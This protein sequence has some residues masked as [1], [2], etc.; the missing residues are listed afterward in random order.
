MHMPGRRPNAPH[1]AKLLSFLGWAKALTCPIWARHTRRQRN[2]SKELPPPPAAREDVKSTSHMRWRLVAALAALIVLILAGV[3]A[4]F[5]A[6]AIWRSSVSKSPKEPQTISAVPSP[7]RAPDAQGPSPRKAQ[8]I[9]RNVV[10]VTQASTWRQGKKPF[11]IE[12]EIRQRLASAGVG[13]VPQ[14]SSRADGT[15]RIIYMETEG[16]SYSRGGKG[17]QISCSVELEGSDS[18]TLLAHQ[19]RAAS[20]FL[21]L[22]F[23]DKDD[24]LY[25]NA[26]G[27]LRGNAVYEHLEYLVAGALGVNSALPHVLTEAL[28]EREARSLALHVLG[29]N[30]FQPSSQVEE[31]YLAA[32]RGQFDDCAR[33]GEAAVEPL[34]RMSEFEEVTLLALSEPFQTQLQII[35]A[36]G[37]IG[38]RTATEKLVEVLDRYA[39]AVPPRVEYT[40]SDVAPPI[41]NAVCGALQH[42]DDPAAKS[43]IEE[44]IRRRRESISRGFPQETLN[45]EIEFLEQALDR[46]NST[47]RS[48]TMRTEPETTEPTSP[49]APADSDQGPRRRPTSF[50]VAPTGLPTESPQPESLTA[51]FRQVQSVA[52]SGGP[53]GHLAD[54]QSGGGASKAELSAELH[55]VFE[56]SNDEVRKI[57]QQILKAYNYEP[58]HWGEAQ[59][60]AAVGEAAFVPNEL[61]RIRT[62]PTLD[63]GM[64]NMSLG[65]ETPLRDQFF[66]PQ[67]FAKHRAVRC[68]TPAYAMWRAGSLARKGLSERRLLQAL[69][70]AHRHVYGR[71][72]F[73]VTLAFW[74]EPGGRLSPTALCRQATE[75][76]TKAKFWVVTGSGRVLPGAQVRF[77]SIMPFDPRPVVQLNPPPARTAREPV[78]ASPGHPVR[79][80]SRE[81]KRPQRTGLADKYPYAKGYAVRH[82]ELGGY[83]SSVVDVGPG[84][85]YLRSG[86]FSSAYAGYCG[87]VTVSVPLRS[88]SSALVSADESALEL[89]AI[90]PV[91]P[92][93]W[94]REEPDLPEYD[95]SPGVLARP[96]PKDPRDRLDES[97]RRYRE[98]SLASNADFV[99]SLREALSRNPRYVWCYFVAEFPL[100]A[101]SASE[102]NIPG[103]LPLA[104]MT[105]PAEVVPE[106]LS[107]LRQTYQSTRNWN[108][109][110]E[111]CTDC[112]GGATRGWRSWV[113]A[114]A[115]AKE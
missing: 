29:L 68:L 7:T 93:A 17:T 40:S 78:T 11:D 89:H 4:V 99:R 85:A 8:A 112:L 25:T 79:R 38:S 100:D 12:S 34:L 51:P 31:A 107:R 5:V 16:G 21:V 36:I 53:S 43:R 47:P 105:D 27:D 35:E 70:T 48:I 109:L 95:E 30:S 64:G 62:M 2:A 39:G 42:I 18:S 19:I 44:L 45:R 24:P 6:G 113:A 103:I 59:D 72:T 28:P 111:C 52:N 13:V 63:L 67:V 37:S 76:L 108:S 33:I 69:D 66:G 86:K 81:L 96:M 87:T 10:I 74:Q 73:E 55:P 58:A 106:E 61:L 91:L 60:I 41:L 3:S 102:P 110:R 49:A 22:T 23:G 20:S 83:D 75:Q 97:R 82:F 80:P 114:Q 15:L 32:G 98:T 9:E 56:L 94:G 71:A 104:D 26:L 65:V 14:G 92:Q 77:G 88:G 101:E 54:S 46:L 84:V 90:L 115:E 50:P 57:R 1:A